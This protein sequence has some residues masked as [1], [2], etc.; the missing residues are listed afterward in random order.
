MGS[1]R[2]CF[3]LSRAREFPS[4]PFHNAA[5]DVLLVRNSR[6]RKGGSGFKFD[7]KISQ[8]DKPESLHLNRFGIR[9]FTS[10]LQPASEWGMLQSGNAQ[11]TESV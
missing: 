2:R 11:W 10:L 8:F 5:S 7:Q 9:C 4:E 6:S 3:N 1:Q